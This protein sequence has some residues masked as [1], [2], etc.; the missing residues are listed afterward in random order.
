MLF[1][2]SI[3]RNR[4]SKWSYPRTFV[5]AKGRRTS[6]CP[7]VRSLISAVKSKI[8]HYEI[9]EMIDPSITGRVPTWPV[10]RGTRE[11][12]NE[13]DDE[14]EDEVDGRLRSRG[15]EKRVEKKEEPRL[16]HKNVK[17]PLT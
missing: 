7:L 6:R 4:E 13:A 1:R 12:R 15:G 8:F 2:E 9:S 10:L 17:L 16:T 5:T 11:Q 3:A 14:V